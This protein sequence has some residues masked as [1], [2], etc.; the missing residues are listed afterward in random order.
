MTQSLDLLSGLFNQRTFHTKFALL[1]I[2]CYHGDTAS[3]ATCWRWFISPC[4][5]IHFRAIGHEILHPDRLAG[6]WR[7]PE[8]CSVSGHTLCPLRGSKNKQT[9]QSEAA[10]FM[11]EGEVSIA[12]FFWYFWYFLCTSGIFKSYEK[13]ALA[14]IWIWQSVTIAPSSSLTG[15]L[16]AAEHTLAWHP[17][18]KWTD[19]INPRDSRVLLTEQDTVSAGARRYTW[20]VEHERSWVL[21]AYTVYRW[22]EGC[23][24]PMFICW[25]INTHYL[26]L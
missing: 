1:L 17:C 12:L 7:L 23:W 19:T 26:C 22:R 16:E 24:R 10:A 2:H 25:E 5:E 3:Q 13:G 6:L 14:N 8:Q 21:I 9:R 4:S 11:K 18:L 15:L 20:P